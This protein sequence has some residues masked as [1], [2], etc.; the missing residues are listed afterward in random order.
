MLV[1]VR[2]LLLLLSFHQFLFSRRG[3]KKEEEDDRII[4]TTKRSGNI[5]S[6]LD[7]SAQSFI[8]RA[9]SENAKH[10]HRHGTGNDYRA[11][12]T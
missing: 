3:I 2:S 11:S 12:E 6:T 5:D 8:I 1:V 10:S 4:D 9:L 7:G